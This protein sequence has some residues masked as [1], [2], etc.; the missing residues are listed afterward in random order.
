MVWSN[1]K[2]Y[3][4]LK[5]PSGLTVVVAFVASSPLGAKPPA[6]AIPKAMSDKIA[7]TTYDAPETCNK[8]INPNRLTKNDTKPA[9]IIF[10]NPL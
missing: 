4:L 2:A 6:V 7:L 9:A 10:L 1:D 8:P 3:I 5:N